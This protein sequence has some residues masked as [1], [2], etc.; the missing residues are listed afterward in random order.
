MEDAFNL[1][2]EFGS[3]REVRRVVKLHER[4][5]K[6]YIARRL[7][8]LW[9]RSKK[10]SVGDKVLVRSSGSGNTHV[11]EVI[12]KETDFTVVRRCH[13]GKINHFDYIYD[14]RSVPCSASIF[15]IH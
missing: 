11:G 8:S 14:R 1:V 13:S 10:I 6:K 4:T 12:Q 7:E 2:A 5:L 3:W 9:D 15:K